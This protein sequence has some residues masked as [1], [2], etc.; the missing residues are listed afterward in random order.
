M[1][2]FGY[3]CVCM[4]ERSNN[5][6]SSVISLWCLAGV[7]FGCKQ[8]QVTSLLLAWGEIQYGRSNF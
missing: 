7:M 4:L 8:T 2:T 6:S 5:E 1:S 3:F